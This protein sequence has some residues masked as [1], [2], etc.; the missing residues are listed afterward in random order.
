MAKTSG[1]QVGWE[2]KH[3][4]RP[5][6]LLLSCL[7]VGQ[8]TYITM[9]ILDL[10]EIHGSASIFEVSDAINCW[11]HSLSASHILLCGWPC[12]ATM[13]E[14]LLPWTLPLPIGWSLGLRIWVTSFCFPIG[15]IYLGLCQP[16]RLEF[17]CYLYAV[18]WGRDGCGKALKGCSGISNG[19][20]SWGGSPQPQPRASPPWR[21]CATCKEPHEAHHFTGL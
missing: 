9:E 8:L 21:I 20:D 18:F 2:L 16:L 13:A 4:K 3:P 1:F 15:D 19:K 17:L 12:S 5:S 11:N 7:Y 10:M 14:E 6:Q